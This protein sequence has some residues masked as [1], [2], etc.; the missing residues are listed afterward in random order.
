LCTDDRRHG[1]SLSLQS[2]GFFL[3]FLFVAPQRV[4]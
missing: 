4:G 1:S 2:S 3:M